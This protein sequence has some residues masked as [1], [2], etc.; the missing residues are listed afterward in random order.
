M[1]S[2][3]SELLNI[4]QPLLMLYSQRIPKQVKEVVITGLCKL[5]QASER[6]GR[7]LRSGQTNNLAHSFREVYSQE[8]NR[9]FTSTWKQLAALK[10]KTRSD[11]LENH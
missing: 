3:R 9:G 4:R 11:F 8:V 1:K 2:N 10:R 6:N 5:K 7:C